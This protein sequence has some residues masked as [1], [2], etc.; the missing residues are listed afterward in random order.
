MRLGISYA[1]CAG[2]LDMSIAEII[3]SSSVFRHLYQ[4]YSA[5]REKYVLVDEFCRVLFEENKGL[6]LIG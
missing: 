4:E 2:R 6:M 1:R 3:S 5:Y